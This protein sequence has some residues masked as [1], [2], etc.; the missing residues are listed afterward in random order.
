MA[1]Q[2]TEGN[3]CQR[4]HS[5]SVR[6]SREACKEREG[7]RERNTQ[8]PKHHGEPCSRYRD[9]AN[10]QRRRSSSPPLVL[11]LKKGLENVDQQRPFSLSSS[12]HTTPCL[13][14]CGASS[15]T[16]SVTSPSP[17]KS[18]SSS[19]NSPFCSDNEDCEVSEVGPVIKNIQNTHKEWRSNS[20]QD[21]TDRRDRGVGAGVAGVAREYSV[22]GEKNGGGHRIAVPVAKRQPQSVQ[23]GYNHVK[24]HHS[25][26]RNFHS[27]SPVRQTAV[28]A[29]P[30]GLM[31]YPPLYD[32]VQFRLHFL[33]IHA[34]AQAERCKYFGVYHDPDSA[35]IVQA[36]STE[37]RGGEKDEE[38]ER[39]LE[40]IYN[41]SEAALM[42]HAEQS[43]K[44]KLLFSQRATELWL[45]QKTLA[46]REAY[47]ARV[48]R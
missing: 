28:A 43:H 36:P 26:A 17:S 23:P 37:Y 31:A 38:L 46:E 4:P 18:C 6:E 39:S 40:R 42:R 22:G 9:S 27:T 5:Q 44:V 2:S 24:I 21:K 16:E 47:K 13:S 29:T 19:G 3:P 48:Q 30:I 34:Q 1:P 33:H 25:G 35:G 12:I 7:F 32:P 10:E 11:E 15:T 45:K 8:R 41:D 20:F 14:S